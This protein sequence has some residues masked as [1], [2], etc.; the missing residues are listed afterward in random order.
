MGRVR[1]ATPRS[2]KVHH[3]P[4]RPPPQV[5]GD[6]PQI[7]PIGHRRIAADAAD[8]DRVLPGCFGRGDV[9]FIGA[10]VDDDHAGRLPQSSARLALAERP[11]K[12]HIDRLAVAD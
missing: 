11:F 12:F 10:V 8:I 6:Y 9:A 1:W 3:P 5:I 4:P 7:E 2:W